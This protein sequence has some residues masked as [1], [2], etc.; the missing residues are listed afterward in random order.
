MAADD[1]RKQKPLWLAIEEHLLELA[2]QDLAGEN[3]EAAVQQTARKLDEAGYNVSRHGGHLLDLRWAM[4]DM[5]KLG[6]PLLEDFNVVVDAL[7]LETAAD[8]Y[9]AA[10]R[11]I[12]DV[13]ATWPKLKL[14]ECR[15]VVIG[16]VEKKRLDL[17][18]TKAGKLPDDQGIELLIKEKV[19]PQVI[20][21]RLNISDEKL[22]EV[23]TAMEKRRAERARVEGLIQAVEGKSDE[24]KVLHLFDNNVSEQL[25]L[26]MAG[27]APSAIEAANK[28][29]E[30]ELK[31]KQRLEEEAAA[32]RKAEAEGPPLE[33]IPPEQMLEHIEAI[34]EIMEFSDKENEIRSMCEQSAI[35]KS[36]VDIAVSEP[37]RLDE[38]EKEAGG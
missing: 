20:T 34:R 26:E 13:G 18:V 8:A 12:G 27:V 1:N 7:T 17:L 19:A 24:E 4:D 16:V 37:A 14:S 5:R 36:L 31:E 30:A 25:I 11:I 22:K 3:R 6:R 32:K 35:P 29:R 21:S 33:A 28:A 9:Q 23:N 10:D 15:P 38:L 2:P